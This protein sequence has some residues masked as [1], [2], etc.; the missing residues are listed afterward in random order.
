[1]IKNKYLLILAGIF[2]ILAGINID[3]IGFQAY[4]SHITLFNILISIII[5]IIFY[6]I[7]FNKLV[8]KHTNR[9]ISSKIE[10]QKFYKFFDLKSYFIMIFMIVLGIVIRILNLLSDTYIGVFYSGLGT[11]LFLSGIKFIINYRKVY[12][13]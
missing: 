10:K 2:W 13:G 6:C 4:K 1:M 12:R 9:I 11:A 8:L 3:K 5:F 7:I